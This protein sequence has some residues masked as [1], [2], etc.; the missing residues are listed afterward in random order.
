MMKLTPQ[1]TNAAL[2]GDVLM[3]AVSGGEGILWKFLIWI[4]QGVGSVN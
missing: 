1:K 2:A 4:I 3:G